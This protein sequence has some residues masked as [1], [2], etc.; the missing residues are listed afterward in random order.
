MAAL[1]LSMIAKSETSRVRGFDMAAFRLNADFED[2]SI[3]LNRLYRELSDTAPS[4]LY[5]EGL[6]RAMQERVVFLKQS[7]A[8]LSD[9]ALDRKGLI[10]SVDDES[11]QLLKDVA[12]RIDDFIA[13][14]ESFVQ[15]DFQTL[16]ERFSSPSVV[17]LVAARNGVVLRSLNGLVENSRAQQQ[18][19]IDLVHTGING[20]V[21]LLLISLLGSWC[22]IVRPAIAKQKL[23]MQREIEFSTSL[24]KKNVELQLAES[25]A[26]VLYENAARGVRARTEF[27]ALI[28]HELRTPLNAI[29]GFSEVM[30]DEV[31]GKHEIATYRDYSNDIYRSGR[32]LLGIISD[33]LQFT[34][35]ESDRCTLE[36][37]VLPLADIFSDVRMMAGDNAAKKNIDLIFRNELPQD[38]AMQVD[39]RLLNQALMNLIDNAIKFSPS[40]STVII[41][42]RHDT[43]K[44]MVISVTDEGIGIDPEI[45]PTLFQPFEQIESAFSRN[46]GGLGLGLSITKKIMVAHDGDVSVVSDKEAGSCFSLHLPTKRFVLQAG[47]SGNG[48]EVPS[49]AEIFA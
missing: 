12:P 13:R 27:L 18:R 46:S 8:E 47:S 49:R 20:A 26:R 11:R 17:D 40:G 28:S 6:Q 9:G 22:W 30:K 10:G 32:H 45:A 23:A 25:H 3:T 48:S 4:Q 44:D 14:T 1:G 19:T 2:V 38:S 36:E 31:F 5:I 16:K 34:Q 35:F 43:G 37:A 15:S 33:I 21:T 42:G 39:R 29:L 7:F 24:S 41:H